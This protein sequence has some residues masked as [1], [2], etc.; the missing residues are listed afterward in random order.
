MGLAATLTLRQEHKEQHRCE[1]LNHAKD[2]IDIDIDRIAGRIRDRHRRCCRSIRTASY[3]HAAQAL[4]ESR[5]FLGELLLK[6]DW[7]DTRH[8]AIV[9]EI[10]RQHT[11]CSRLV[12]AVRGLQA[13]EALLQLRALRCEHQATRGDPLDSSSPRVNAGHN[14][15]Q[16]V[17]GAEETAPTVR[18]R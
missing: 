12:C 2:Q 5:R 1:M 6:V 16:G 18:R 14:N 10:G 17:G 8:R 13:D 9:S 7:A 4:R 15:R 3:G 11:A